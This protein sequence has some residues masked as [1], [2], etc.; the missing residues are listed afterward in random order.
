MAHFRK[1]HGTMAVAAVVPGRRVERLH[2]TLLR[3]N[4]RSVVGVFRYPPANI[5]CVLEL[6][7][8]NVRKATIGYSL[9]PPNSRKDKRV[10]RR[11]GT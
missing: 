11:S 1:A 10:Y 3:T 5:G 9:G 8:S 4:Q 2:R 7:R 6:K